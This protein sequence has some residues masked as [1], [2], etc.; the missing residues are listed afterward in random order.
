MYTIDIGA[1]AQGFISKL[2]KI[3]K[4][5]ILDKISELENYPFLGKKLRGRL[6]GLRCLRVDEFRVIYT[7]KD[8]EL[9]I[10]VLKVGE[11]RKVYK[12]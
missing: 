10:L 4:K 3:K 12:I 8:I 9:L 11:R 5:K 2:D 7:L 1:P 6:M